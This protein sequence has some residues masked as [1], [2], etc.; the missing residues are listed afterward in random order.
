M[1]KA[2]SGLIRRMRPLLGLLFGSRHLSCPFASRSVSLCGARR[3][4]E[5]ILFEPIEIFADIEG[6]IHEFFICELIL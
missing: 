2:L 4:V 5:P 6:K 1:I 3:A